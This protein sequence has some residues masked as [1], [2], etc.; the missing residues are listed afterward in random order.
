MSVTY[1]NAPLVELVAELR[2][3]PGTDTTTQ[4]EQG[5]LLAMPAS[6]DE[7]IYMQFGAV[8]S[9]EGYGRFER[10]FPPGVPIPVG[11]VAIRCRPNDTAHQSPLFQLGHGVFSANALPPYKSWRDFSPVVRKGID[12]LFDA[13]DRSEVARPNFQMALIRYIDAFKADLSDGRDVLSFL[14]DV[15]SLTIALPD[16]ILS[17]VENARKI[18]P[19]LQL[20]VPTSLGR[21]EIKFSEG[22]A[23]NQQAIIMDSSLQ[24][25]RDMGASS[26]AAMDTLTEGREV[27]HELFRSLTAPIHDQMEPIS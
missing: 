20:I 11:N 22:S 14:H 19:A 7:E 25:L 12:C 5:L 3:G 1:N 8:L 26:D 21:M 16:A 2:W 23:G 24:I 6:K 9:A 10:V 4:Q 18:V 13:F 17:K 27:I 15:M